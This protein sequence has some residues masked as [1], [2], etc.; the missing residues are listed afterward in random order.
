MEQ[1]DF[2]S[3]TDLVGDVM[4]EMDRLTNK[5]ILALHEAM[6]GIK[7]QSET[8]AVEKHMEWFDNTI[9]PWYQ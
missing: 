3:D 4:K 1:Y 2:S 7:E 8:E 6:Q 9:L 5:E